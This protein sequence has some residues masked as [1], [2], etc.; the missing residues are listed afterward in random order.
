MN[1]TALSPATASAQNLPRAQP[2]GTERPS[3]SQPLSPLG[4]IIVFLVFFA[5]LTGVFLAALYFY[6]QVK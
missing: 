1:E 6:Y 2:L 4:Q 3:G 5:I